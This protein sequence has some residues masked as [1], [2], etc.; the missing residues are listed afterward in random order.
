MAVASVCRLPG[1]ARAWTQPVTPERVLMGCERLKREAR[2][3]TVVV[4]TAAPPPSFPSPQGGGKPAQWF[5]NGIEPS[6]SSPSPLWGGIKGGG[7][8]G[9]DCGACR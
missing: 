2:G 8:F 1:C 5:P 7:G 9:P 4:S 6:A 3:S